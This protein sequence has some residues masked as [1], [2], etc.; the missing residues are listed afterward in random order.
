MLL[1]PFLFVLPIGHDQPVY[2]RPW[3]TIALIAICTA[4]FGLTTFSDA[5]AMDD[6]DEAVTRMDAIAASHPDAR[7]T[8]SV[9]DLPEGIDA[10]V[11][12]LIDTSPTRRSSV[13]DEEMGDALH[14]VLDALGRL[15]T[16]RWG[17]RPGRP[18]V[19]RAATSMFLHADLF[20][21]AGNMLFLFIAGGV[22]E[23]FWRRWTYL[24]LYFGSG[25]AAIVAH[26]LADPSGLTPVVGASGA[27]GGLMGAFLVA[28]NGAKIRYACGAWLHLPIYFRGDHY[29]SSKN[30]IRIG[31]WLIGTLWI[32]F[33]TFAVPAWVVLPAWV[34]LEIASALT[35][36]A[37]MVAHWAHLGGFAFGVV[38]A[39]VAKRM[40]WIA[41]DAGESRDVGALELEPSRPPA[42][43]PRAVSIASPTMDDLPLPSRSMPP[44]SAPVSPSRRPIEAIE[45]DSLPAAG[46]DDPYER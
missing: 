12:P 39:L 19:A 10:I 21:L 29:G 27:I 4:L 28:H 36:D 14:D 33:R 32:F 40:L 8:F 37:P 18:S 34:G 46:D 44:M 24:T 25:I 9:E 11:Q 38:L 2:E 13:G 43:P 3:V 6:L 23:C 42:R 31:G 16:L 41:E 22:L 20:H 1:L 26:T 15:S 30:H 35:G 7:A 5:S 45:L 17:Y